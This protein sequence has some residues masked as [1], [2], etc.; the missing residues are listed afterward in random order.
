[1][2]N[3]VKTQR[4][5]GGFSLIELMIV[6][7]IIGILA[8]IAYPSYIENV[9]E[10]RRAT[11][12][13]ALVELANYMER[14]YTENY[15]YPDADTDIPAAIQNDLEQYTLAI[16]ASTATSFTLSAVPQGAQTADRCGDLTLNHIGVKE[17][18]N[19]D[20]GVEAADC[21]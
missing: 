10:T 16:D 4:H 18:E 6:V 7:V 13:A 2:R 1:M 3:K 17:I 11:A 14:F 15:T 20:P 12:Q 8:G 9:R 19:A 21:W 5:S